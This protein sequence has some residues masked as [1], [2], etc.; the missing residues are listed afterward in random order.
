MTAFPC[1]RGGLTTPARVGIFYGAACMDTGAAAH[2]LADALV[3]LTGLDL[4]LADIGCTDMA[5]L[6]RYDA[7]LLGCPTRQGELPPD[8]EA[9]FPAFQDLDLSGRAV[10][11]FGCDDQLAAPRTF[12]DALGILAGAASSVWP[13]TPSPSPNCRA[14]ACGAGWPA[15]PTNSA[16][17]SA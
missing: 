1:L 4:T 2:G 3:S 9:A 15:S 13:W 8:W 7:L 5:D 14:T 12:Q 16:G 6:G 10:G 17:P 11:L